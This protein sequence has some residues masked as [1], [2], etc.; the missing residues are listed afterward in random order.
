MNIGNHTFNISIQHPQKLSMNEIFNYAYN[1]NGLSETPLFNLYKYFKGACENSCLNLAKFLYEKEPEIV[2]ELVHCP[3]SYIFLNSCYKGELQ[4]VKWLVD[5]FNLDSSFIRRND[6]KA[7]KLAYVS[8]EFDTI[9]WLVE[10]F[11]ITPEEIGRHCLV[12]E[13]FYECSPRY[14]LFHDE[15]WHFKNL[16]WL[17][18]TFNLTLEN[19]KCSD[20]FYIACVEGNFNVVAWF[21]ETFKTTPEN[22]LEDR[23]ENA[24]RKIRSHKA[25]FNV[26]LKKKISLSEI[27][28]LL[29][30]YFRLK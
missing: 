21:I 6:F 15:K 30:K 7:I 25:E 23:Y 8:E 18:D 17:V 12:T 11:N 14:Y 1:F 27:E 19:I 3:D 29:L 26:T 20:A 16:K 4:I 9:I 2:R 13:K 10:R 24:L 22:I 28:K 5:E